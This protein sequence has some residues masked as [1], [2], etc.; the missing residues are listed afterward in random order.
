M[1]T[2]CIFVD[3][4]KETGTAL[5]MVDEATAQNE[6]L[7]VSG[8]CGA[9]TMEDVEKTRPLIESASILLLQ[10]EINFDVLYKVIEIAHKA[11]VTVVLNTAPAAPVPDEVLAMV[12]IVTPNEVEAALLTGVK[13]EKPEDARAA[14]KVFLAK[15]VRQVVIT[16]GAMGAY[17]TDG[18]REQFLDRLPV[19]AV[20]TTGAG[21]AFNGGFVMALAQGKDLFTAL[22][23]GN[24][25]GALSVTKLGTA[26]S[27]PKA[28][29]I[30]A[31]YRQSY[32]E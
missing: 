4:E 9:F 22:R 23:Y 28:Q 6:I 31:F 30:E 3:P 17:A 16:L 19:K 18:Q 14:A 5:I 32:G 26:P 7:V 29:E 15:G 21:D 10:M 8:A 2:G 11:G 27:M 24:V 12:D 13:I 20:E 25:T 1:D